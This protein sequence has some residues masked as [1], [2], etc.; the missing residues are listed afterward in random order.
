[1]RTSDGRRRRSVLSARAP[2]LRSREKSRVAER[3]WFAADWVRRDHVSGDRVPSPGENFFPI[4]TF[5]K[6]KIE[7]NPTNFF[8][9][10]LF[11]SKP[12]LFKST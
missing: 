2:G 4:L 5:L 1:V 10:N 9:P 3:N 12:Y 6:I 7:I 8:K 11:K